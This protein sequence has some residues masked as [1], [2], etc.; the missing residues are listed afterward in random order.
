MS[1]KILV[2]DDEKSSVEAT[3]EA[4]EREGYDLYA[5]AGGR[6][7]LKTLEEERIDVVITDLQMPDLSG[8]E[9]LTNIRDRAP[10]TQVII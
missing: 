5:A 8:I 4:L 3:V 9:L 2:V 10:D 1:A 6:E 7:A